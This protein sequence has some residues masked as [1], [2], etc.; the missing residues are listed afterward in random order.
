[1]QPRKPRRE[2]PK[3]RGFGSYRKVALGA[4]GVII[5]LLVIAFITGSLPGIPPAGSANATASDAT[6]PGMF[7]TIIMGILPNQTPVIN[8]AT[9]VVTDTPLK[10]KG[11]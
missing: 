1:V 10:P 5:L 11:T 8:Q 7:D 9:P 6:A 2:A 4:A 3:K